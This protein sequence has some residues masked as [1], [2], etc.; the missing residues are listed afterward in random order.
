MIRILI[1]AVRAAVAWLNAPTRYDQSGPSVPLCIEAWILRPTARVGFRHG[2]AA[3]A[4][5]RDNPPKR[6]TIPLN[7]AWMVRSC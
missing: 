2:P 7:T 3:T 6:R 4:T 5:D 1:R